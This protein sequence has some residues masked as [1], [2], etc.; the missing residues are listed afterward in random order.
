M[1]TVWASGPYNIWGNA[2]GGFATF[3]YTSTLT[4]PFN[5]SED[6]S[7]TGVSGTTTVSGNI[8]S[9][10]SFSHTFNLLAG[11]ADASGKEDFADYTAVL[12]NYGM[13]GGWDAGDFN[14]D[15][16]VNFSDYTTVL[17]NYGKSYTGGLMTAVPEPN[18]IALLVAMALSLAGLGL[19]KRARYWVSGK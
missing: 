12:Q 6:F 9:V 14:G 13:G 5:V 15:G 10:G 19:W 3:N 4:V 11:D 8:V 1:T 17:Q 2:S 7:E 18:S 16:T